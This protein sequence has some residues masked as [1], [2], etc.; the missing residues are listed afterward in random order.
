MTSTYEECRTSP[1]VSYMALSKII[2]KIGFFVFPL[3]ILLP[4][5]IYICVHIPPFLYC[6]YPLNIDNRLLRCPVKHIASYFHMY[7]CTHSAFPISFVS[8]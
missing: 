7:M 1:F 4:I 3:N 6:L 8:I 2:A 5:F